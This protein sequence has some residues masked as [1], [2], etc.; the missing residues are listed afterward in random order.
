MK[1]II[2]EVIIDS[3]L[4]NFDFMR[5]MKFHKT[6]SPIEYRIFY[7]NWVKEEFNELSKKYKDYFEKNHKMK[8]KTGFKDQIEKQTIEDNQQLSK[9]KTK[10]QNEEVYSIFMKEIEIDDLNHLQYTFPEKIVEKTLESDI[11]IFTKLN[12]LNDILY[13]LNKKIESLNSQMSFLEFELGDYNYTLNYY[14]DLSVHM[15][16]IK[17]QLETAIKSLDIESRNKLIS[18]IIE[19]SNVSKSKNRQLQPTNKIIWYGKESDFEY[20]IDLLIKENWITE[21]NTFSIFNKHFQKKDGKSFNFSQVKENRKNTK[22]GRIKNSEK[23]EK[24]VETV[25]KERKKPL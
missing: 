7:L 21:H 24:I 18:K 3:D 4:F 6:L 16:K 20:L 17:T 5:I 1:D 15:N 2:P 8:F 13:N 12:I 22:S 23:I 11:D 10:L 9:L 19:Q 25:K 14:C